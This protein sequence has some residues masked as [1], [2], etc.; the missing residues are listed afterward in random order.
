M[1]KIKQ[2]KAKK[3]KKKGKLF[4]C[5]K[6]HP[7][8]TFFSSFGNI[9]S[10][11]ILGSRCIFLKKFSIY[12]KDKKFHTFHSH[13]GSYTHTRRH[14]YSWPRRLLCTALPSAVCRTPNR[15]I[16]ISRSPFSH[17]T[18]RSKTFAYTSSLSL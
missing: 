12:P 9:I 13:L 16:C 7:V 10:S 2:K 6:K 18:G 15:S 14:P 5:Y 1:N 8:K 4:F 3:A 17:S 11:Y